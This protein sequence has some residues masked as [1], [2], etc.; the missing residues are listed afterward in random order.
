MDLFD[1]M[2]IAVGPHIGSDHLPVMLILDVIPNLRPKC[3]RPQWKLPTTTDADFWAHWCTSVDSYA[4][5]D[6][7]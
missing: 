4:V 1:K 6:L 5:K 7:I 3:R 2:S